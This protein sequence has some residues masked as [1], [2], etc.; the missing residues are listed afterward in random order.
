LAPK[1]RKLFFEIFSV[2][3]DFTTDA[4]KVITKIKEKIILHKKC[5]KTFFHE[6]NISDNDKSQSNYV[7]NK[8]QFTWLITIFY[9]II[10]VFGDT[11]ERDVCSASKVGGNK[12]NFTGLPFPTDL[13]KHEYRWLFMDIS[14]TEA[15]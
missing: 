13:V 12:F 3:I 6:S 9:P 11:H 4:Y 8:K 7:K 10:F 2:T 15:P 1:Q 5:L 14:L